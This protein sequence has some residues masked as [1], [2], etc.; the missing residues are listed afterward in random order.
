[1]RPAPEVDL[2]VGSNESTSGSFTLRS[3]SALSYSGFVGSVGSAVEPLEQEGLHALGVS[4]GVANGGSGISGSLGGTQEPGGCRSP[5]GTISGGG[6]SWQKW[7]NKPDKD[8]FAG[9]S[10]AT[11]GGLPEAAE[12]LLGSQMGTVDKRAL[13]SLD[14]SQFGLGG[15]TSQFGLDGMRSMWDPLAEYDPCNST[16][17]VLLG[18]SLDGSSLIGGISSTPSVLGH[19]QGQWGSRGMSKDGFSTTSGKGKKLQ[20]ADKRSGSVRKGLA[21]SRPHAVRVDTRVGGVVPAA[22]PIRTISSVEENRSFHVYERAGHVDYTGRQVRLRG[23]FQTRQQRQ[24][25]A[26][27]NA[28]ERNTSYLPRKECYAQLGDYCR[29][30]LPPTP[31]NARLRTEA[32]KGM[33]TG[34]IPSLAE[35]NGSVSP[36]TASWT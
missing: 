12:I 21:S 2:A 22:S 31:A 35:I 27:T 25:A 14:C 11:G 3:T 24:H 26:S 29:S 17:S 36:P 8:A 9:A 5:F 15:G 32:R 6:W 1:M 7:G 4:A 20:R 16:A 18:S 34:E 33:A 19:S 23:R 10:G 28:S 30:H 13:R